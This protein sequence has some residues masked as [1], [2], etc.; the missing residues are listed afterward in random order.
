MEVLTAIG[1]FVIS[2]SFPAELF[3]LSKSLSVFQVFSGSPEYYFETDLV[4]SIEIPQGAISRRDYFFKEYHPFDFCLGN[5]NYLLR[6]NFFDKRALLTVLSEFSDKRLLLF[7]AFKWFL[8]LITIDNGGIPLHSSNVFRYNKALLF[9]G[10]SG[11]GKSTICQ[12]ISKNPQYEKGSDELNLILP[13]DSTAFAYSTPYLSFEGCVRTGGA[14]LKHLFF[15]RQSPENHLKRLEAKDKY[16]NI[17]KNIYTIPANNAFA[18]KMYN[19]VQ[20]ISNLINCSELFFINNESILKF[21]ED[22]MNIKNV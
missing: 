21:I 20:N 13:Y 10:K 15:L 22:W 14:P 9:S 11:A 8:S 3:Q 18:E 1:N 2:V 12:I 17:L 7:N 6:I 19:N 16:W 5:E 4:D